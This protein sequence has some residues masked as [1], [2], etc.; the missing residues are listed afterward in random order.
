MARNRTRKHESGK[1]IYVRVVNPPE[2]PAKILP[3]EPVRYSINAIL[4]LALILF[5]GLWTWFYSDWFAAFSGTIGLTVLLGA[6]PTLRSFMSSDHHDKW[7]DWIDAVLFK[8]RAA[9]TVYPILLAILILFGFGLYQPV[10]IRSAEAGT[11]V[12]TVTLHGYPDGEPRTSRLQLEPG[13]TQR[14]PVR[15]PILGGPDRVVVNA[16]ALPVVERSLT[17]LAWKSLVFPLDFWAEP[18]VLLH[19]AP[20]ILADLRDQAHDLWI[21]LKRAGAEDVTC[22]VQE[23][24]L[25]EPVW[26]GTKS[27]ALPV[28]DQTQNAWREQASLH[29]LRRGPQNLATYVI[30][31]PIS[32]DCLARLVPEDVVEWELLGSGGTA[33][34]KGSITIGGTESYPLEIAMEGA[35]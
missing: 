6:V 5:A 35:T 20:S 24:Y 12:V 30:A 28:S 27:R 13:R 31:T 17:G 2:E 32:P 26:L 19:P 16:R 14:Q 11:D 25:G 9:T 15:R 22:M 3:T 23:D 34:R 21:I 4:L 1:R 18:S 29:G 33:L 10:A 7:S 8:S